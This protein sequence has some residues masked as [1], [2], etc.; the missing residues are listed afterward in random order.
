MSTGQPD[1]FSVYGRQTCLA[2]NIALD[3]A[4]CNVAK[5]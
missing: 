1:E 2:G 4:E 5:L 3:N